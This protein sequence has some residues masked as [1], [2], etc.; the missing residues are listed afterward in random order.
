MYLLGLLLLAMSGHPNFIHASLY[1]I[2]L[3]VFSLYLLLDYITK[4]APKNN[5]YLITF[6]LLNFLAFYYQYLFFG[7]NTWL[8]IFGLCSKIIIG[9]FI[10]LRLGQYV[11]TILFNSMFLIGLIS[12]PLMLLNWLGYQI[13]NIFPITNLD[14]D[15]LSILVHVQIKNHPRNCGIFWE[16]GAFAGYIILV[17]LIKGDVSAIKHYKFKSLVFVLT[18][19]STMSTTGY[20]LSAIIFLLEL[21]KFKVSIISKLSLTILFAA[22][23]YLVY[24]KIEFLDSK[25]N[26]QIEHTQSVAGDYDKGRFGAFIFDLQYIE[27]HPLFGNGLHE[28]TRYIDHKWAANI[29]GHGNGMSNYIA[30]MGLIS[31]C[32][33]LYF[34]YRQNLH[35]QKVLW[36]LL[37]LI[38]TE[39]YFDYPFIYGLLVASS[40]LS[41]SIK[42]N[43]KTHESYSRTNNL[44][45]SQ[46]KNFKVS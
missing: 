31:F 22:I 33:F 39:Q 5:K 30:R 41:L 19:L 38:N 16:P 14:N 23:F 18:M 17:W 15:F 44:S 21:F 27:K 36:V 28:K 40:N 35:N 1:K 10:F 12:L 29:G 20:L 25:I 24:S 43:F 11:G 8:G 4:S 42:T 7:W 32:A 9:Y 34:I 2:L 6:I 26:D 37:L 45:Q 46:R 13:P 3:S